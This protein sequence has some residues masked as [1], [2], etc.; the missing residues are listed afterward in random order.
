METDHIS[1]RLAR[2]PMM[3][4]YEV[5]AKYTLPEVAQHTRRFRVQ[6]TRRRPTRKTLGRHVRGRDR[7]LLRPVWTKSATR[8]VHKLYERTLLAV[9]AQRSYFP[10]PYIYRL[11]SMLRRFL[12][13][14]CR[15]IPMHAFA[16]LFTTDLIANDCCVFDWIGTFNKKWWYTYMFVSYVNDVNIVYLYNCLCP[17]PRHIDANSGGKPSS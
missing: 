12:M 2:D 11:W 13:F 7:R 4:H 1:R 15:N 9:V 3:C 17:V 6:H 8:R 5:V 14:R 16:R 10:E